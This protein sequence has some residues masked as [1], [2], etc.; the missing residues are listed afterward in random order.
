MLT[1][2]GVGAGE[3]VA[4]MGPSGSGK[5]TL[6]RAIAGFGPQPQGRILIDDVDVLAMPAWKRNNHFY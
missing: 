5:S 3:R 2:A 1:D 4:I 6:L